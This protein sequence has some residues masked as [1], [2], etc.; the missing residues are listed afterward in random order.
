M[1]LTG[2]IEQHL[3]CVLRLDGN[4]V[5]FYKYKLASFYSYLMDQEMPPTPPELTNNDVA[6]VLIGGK[7]YKWVLSIKHQKKKEFTFEWKSSFAYAVLQAKKGLERPD[8]K[9]IQNEEFETFKKLVTKKKD[10]FY[11][12]NLPHDWSK[13]TDNNV[14]YI[15]SKENIK[16]QLK[17]TVREILKE[18]S[19]TYNDRVQTFFP[20]TNANYNN[21]KSD[22]GTLGFIFEHEDLFLKDLMS[23][24][25]LV[26]QIVHESGKSNLIDIIN[27]TMLQEKFEIL[28]NR[29]QI[30]SRT[31]MAIAIPLGL[32]EAL[33]ARVITKGPPAHYFILKPLQRFLWKTLFQ[34]ESGVF[35]LIGKPVDANIVSES[36]GENRDDEEF[37]SVDYSDA[38]N[39]IRAWVSECIMD[40]ISNALNLTSDERTA[41]IESLTQHVLELKLETKNGKKLFP[42]NKLKQLQE[43]FKI[44]IDSESI[45]LPQKE[46]QLMGSIIS[47]PILCIA[48]AAILRWTR[49][50]DTYRDLDL[51]RSKILVNGDDGLLRTTKRG[52]QVWELIASELGLKPSVG[53]VYYSKEFLNINSALFIKIEPIVQKENYPK[54]NS[55]MKK[56]KP[57]ITFLKEVNYPNMGI[58]KGYKRSTK[59]GTDK[60]SLRDIMTEQSIG[61]NCTYLINN[62]PE[63]IKGKAYKLFLNENWQLLQR[64]KIPWYLPER[65]GGLG[66]PIGKYIDD[67]GNEYIHE[68]SKEDLRTAKVIESYFSFTVRPVD[69]DFEIWKLAQERLQDFKF[70]PTNLEMAVLQGPSSTKFQDEETLL[71]KL[72]VEALFRNSLKEIYPM[73]AKQAELEF[74]ELSKDKGTNKRK[75]NVLLNRNPLRQLEKIIRGARESSEIRDGRIVGYSVKE[76]N[77]YKPP[78]IALP[79]YLFYDYSFFE[80][81][82]SMEKQD[83]VFR[84]GT[85]YREGRNYNDYSS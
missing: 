85:E 24:D 39:G 6:H 34:H 46:G 70:N 21:T 35:K 23:K 36:I 3:Q 11:L 13:V 14:E 79:F 84:V 33:K 68:P 49:E 54:W 1:A 7:F 12:K 73:N 80:D 78:P 37:L 69:K 57:K 74:D 83:E 32:A 31:E 50:V 44:D 41:C 53:K 82:L 28:Y 43:Q 8:K 29:I 4:W 61:A 66:L 17:R 20:S 77:T 72:C 56:F 48:N 65:L 76:L 62:C 16:T 58:I 59:G 15:L 71:G 30:Y 64:Y 63:N 25:K 19:Y 26:N 38:T 27:D 55:Y 60:I 42:L 47:F 45:Q 81:P 52:K 9:F 18:K 67:E 10:N 5:K 40:E 51:S 2:T 75:I 22:A